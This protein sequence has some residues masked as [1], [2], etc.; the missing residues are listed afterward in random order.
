MIYYF[1]MII[2]PAA[3]IV[4]IIRIPTPLPKFIF[5]LE[6]H[7]PYSDFHAKLPLMHDL[8]VRLTYMQVSKV[9]ILLYITNNWAVSMES[10][11]LANAHS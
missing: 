3:G 6:M 2:Y 10:Y 7:V 8:L 1:Q 4:P 11:G 5:W 9:M